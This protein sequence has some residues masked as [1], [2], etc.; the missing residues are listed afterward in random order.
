MAKSIVAANNLKINSIID[1]K[2]I[3][4]K[5]PGGGLAPYFRDKILGKKLKKNIKKDELIKFED[6]Y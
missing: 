1:L 6:F 5:S 4:F 3:A 2:D